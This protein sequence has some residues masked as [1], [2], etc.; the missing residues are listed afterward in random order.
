MKNLNNYINEALIKKS[1]KI[2][3][4]EKIVKSVSEIFKYL[5]IDKGHE[6]EAKEII[7]KWLIDNKVNKYDFITSKENLSDIIRNYD[8]D[9]NRYDYSYDSVG[10]CAE[11]LV[12]CDD[13]HELNKYSDIYVNEFM[14]SHIFKYGTIYCIKIK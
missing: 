1:T 5:C 14:I 6:E 13:I 12:P 11:R 8:V 10:E 9:I 7:E 4:D 2:I 3:S